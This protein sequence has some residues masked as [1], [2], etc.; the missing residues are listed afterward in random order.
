MT[1]YRHSSLSA[2]DS[3]ILLDLGLTEQDG[4]KQDGAKQGYIGLASSQAAPV[5][6]PTKRKDRKEDVDPKNNGNRNHRKSG[7]MTNVELLEARRL[8]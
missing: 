2:D 3:F 4:T 1:L 8:T 5:R 6:A 7:G